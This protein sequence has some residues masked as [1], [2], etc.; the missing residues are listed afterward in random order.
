MYNNIFFINTLENIDTNFKENNIDYILI[1]TIPDITN[2]YNSNLNLL[3]DS[4]IGIDISNYFGYNSII[5]TNINKKIIQNLLKNIVIDNK[6][7]SLIS[8]YYLN[9]NYENYNKNILTNL[10][11]NIINLH[12]KIISDCEFCFKKKYD[13]DIINKAVVE[14]FENNMSN[15]IENFFIKIKV[16]YILSI[17][18]NKNNYNYLLY[19][20][21]NISNKIKSALGLN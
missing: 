7:N 15:I 17:I 2:T 5:N 19:F 13:L 4:I 6:L 1:D 10:Y 14:Y 20:E 9:N 16:F 21:E 8:H 3:K 18:L 12:I 11:N